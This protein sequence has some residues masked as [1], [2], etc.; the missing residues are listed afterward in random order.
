M[1]IGEWSRECSSLGVVELIC[2]FSVINFT[3][4]TCWRHFISAHASGLH[5]LDHPCYQPEG[6][7]FYIYDEAIIDASTASYVE[8]STILNTIQALH[9][10]GRKNNFKAMFVVGDQQLYDRMCVLVQRHSMQ[11]NWVIPV[12]GDFHFTGHTV[13]AFNDLWFLPFSKSIVDALGF[14]KVIKH[15]DDNITHFKHYDHFYLLLTLGTVIFLHETFDAAV[16]AS[17]ELLL[18]QLA[19]HQGALCFVFCIIARKLL[20]SGFSQVQR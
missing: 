1:R 2:G 15:K 9:I 5:I 19:L 16:L 13:G 17:P 7:H 20:T 14:E 11:Y 18:G 3:H 12:N 8:G 6:P 4:I 10:D